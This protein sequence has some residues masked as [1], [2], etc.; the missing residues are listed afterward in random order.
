MHCV[1]LYPVKNKLANINSIKF[2]K[3]RLKINIG[4]SDHTI[5]IAASIMAKYLGANFIEKHFTLD[6]NYSSFRDHQISSNP[7]EMKILV[8]EVNKVNELSGKVFKKISSEEKK[9]IKS[10]RRSIYANKEIKKGEKITQGNVKIVR[11]HKYYEP[12]DLDKILN[13]K[14]NKKV[15]KIHNY[16]KFIKLKILI[17]STNTPHHLFFYE[18]LSKKFKNINIILEKKN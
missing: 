10:M 4:Y 16:P 12:K 5:G 17:L 7:K 2:L 6:K 15:K 3:S 14:V 13:K 18:S 11:P 9:N 1:S 8:N